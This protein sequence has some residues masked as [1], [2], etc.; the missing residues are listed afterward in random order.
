LVQARLAGTGLRPSGISRVLGA[1]GQ[2]LERLI[3][4][5]RTPIVDDQDS[6]IC[7]LTDEGRRPARK[8][9]S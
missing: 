6:S 2:A 8:T 3:A 1:A 7:C 5:E 4:Q 9:L